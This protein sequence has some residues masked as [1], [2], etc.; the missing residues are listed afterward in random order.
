[1]GVLDVGSGTVF[2]LVVLVAVV[3]GLVV[4]VLAAVDAGRYPESAFEQAGTSKTLWIVLP[5]VGIAACGVVAIGAAIG[6]YVSVKPRVVAAA[7]GPPA[8]GRP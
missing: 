7:G 8:A 4:P 5:L 1:M 3:L 6:W 2:V